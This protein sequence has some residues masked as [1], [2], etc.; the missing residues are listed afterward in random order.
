MGQPEIESTTSSLKGII[1]IV[2]GLAI[3][4]SIITVLSKNGLHTI[5]NLDFNSIL[6]FSIFLINV[7]RFHHGNVRH[8]DTTYKE[9]LGKANITH[10]PVGSSGKTALDFFVIFIQ[11]ILFAWMS[12][13]LKEPTEFFGLFT[14]VLLIDILWYLTVHG[15]AKDKESFQHQKRWTINNV[16]S[17]L[18]LFV[19]FL[20][21]DKIGIVWFTYASGIVAGGNAFVDFWIS[22]SFYFPTLKFTEEST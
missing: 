14:L 20:I 1:V 2:A 9:E 11:S 18:L 15:M 22:W 19:I 4:N 16:L 3:T 5:S 8:L 6:L 17:L 7:I 21:A 10:K 13:L 12:F